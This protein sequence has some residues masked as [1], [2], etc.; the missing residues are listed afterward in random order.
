MTF[1]LNNNAVVKALRSNLLVN[2]LS[3]RECAKFGPSRGIFQVFCLKNGDFETVIF[4]LK[5]RPKTASQA[6]AVLP[7]AL[8]SKFG[9]R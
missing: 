2:T 8:R 6:L 5:A 4:W 7:T 1:I 3:S 9:E